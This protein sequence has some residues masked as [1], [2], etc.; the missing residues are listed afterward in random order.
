[1]P[2]VKVW[3]LIRAH[4]K[5]MQESTNEYIIKRK[6][7][8]ISSL[9]IYLSFPPFLPHSISLSN[10]SIYLFNFFFKKPSTAWINWSGAQGLIRLN[11]RVQ[12]LLSYW[13]IYGPYRCKIEIPV[14]L[15][16]AAPFTFIPRSLHPIH[17]LPC[18][19]DFPLWYQLQYL[20]KLGPQTVHGKLL[21]V[22]DQ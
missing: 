7:K 9:S 17:S 15:A 22:S 19:F 5:K 18:I 6:N 8:S 1:M 2:S 4:V 14:S 13:Q 11:Q 21:N 3:S 12:A 10:Q 16:S 20:I